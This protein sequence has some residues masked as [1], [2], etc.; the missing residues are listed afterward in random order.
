[1]IGSG[2]T[3]AVRKKF[4][5]LF[6]LMLAT[7][8]LS[9]SAALAEQ[10]ETTDDG[11]TWTLSDSGVLTVTGT[12]EVT[13]KPYQFDSDTVRSLVVG[14]GVTKVR[15]IFY[16]LS[17]LTNLSLPDTVTELGLGTFFWCRSLKS[18][19]LPDN[20]S[21]L[22]ED[23]FPQDTKLFSRPGTATARALGRIGRGFST[24]E[25]ALY[26]LKYDYQD[27]QEIGLA[28]M[29][30][31]QAVTSFTVP[32]EITVIGDEAFS[33]CASLSEIVLH[34]GIR[35]IGNRAFDGCS[36]LKTITVPAG[37]SVVSSGAFVGC[38]ALRYAAIGT[39]GA[40]ALGRADYSFRIPGETYTLQYF[41]IIG[42]GMGLAMES[43]AKNTTKLIVPEGVTTLAYRL[44]ADCV[45]P[46][47]YVE[48]PQSITA[49]NIGVFAGQTREFYIKCQKGSYA[50]RF[51][52]ENGLQF[53]NGSSR[54]IGYQITDL[55][56]K[57]NFVVSNYVTKGM[58]ER[59]KVRA[60]HDWLVHNAHYDLTYSNYSAN[61]VLLKGYGVCQSYAEA[62]EKLLT[63]AGLA[64]RLLS[65]KANN[66]TGNG[67]EGHAWNLV[68]VDGQWYHLDVT[69]DDP[70]F[71]VG[72][73]AQD[74]SPAISGM[75]GYSYFLLTDKQI[76]KDHQWASGISADKNQVGTFHD[77]GEKYLDFKGGRYRL[78][79]AKKTAEL[80]GVKSDKVKKLEIPDEIEEGDAV[81]KVTAISAE[82]CSGLKKLASLSVGGEVKTIGEGAFRDC[83]KLSA[84]SLGKKVKT[85]GQN[86]FD[87]CDALK[88]IRCSAGSKAAA[89]ALQHGYEINGSGD[90]SEEAVTTVVLDGLKYELN[91]KKKTAVFA[92]SESP[93]LA[94]LVIPAQVMTE[95]GTRYKV[96]EIKAKACKSMKNLESL[97]VG[98]NVKSIGQSAFENCG[99]LKSVTF[100]TKNLKDSTVGKNAFR[101]IS[102][103][104]TFKCPKKKL[105]DYQE[106][107]P[108]KGAPKKSKFK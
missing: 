86:V 32:P 34:A 84:V 66:G 50:E 69:W 89:W 43:C 37:V 98:Q 56:K 22:G 57:V 53:D 60:I 61:G 40:K 17:N 14:P 28:V 102:K 106:F 76:G 35:K 2:G 72:R 38:D 71:S 3:M 11:M 90:G 7:V 64:N 79:A 46:L 31:N 65:G 30:V 9:F 48:L 25:G 1:M 78:N 58:S 68:R 19:S 92:G 100:K 83:Q 47:E 85:I 94:V 87:G 75:E 95:D 5:L 81:Y 59:Q 15:I 36:A 44:F 108:K 93:D 97:T 13:D 10:T 99:N 41:N 63:R 29:N 42:G 33:G 49:L 12:G 88:S 67:F 26:D 73:V 70:V 74:S 51:A 52:R 45:K 55:T 54:V 96:T 20:I 8:V 82:C 18:V 103:K 105:K 16:H 91:A 80:I 6:L 104:A 21:V 101:K 62:T 4:L 77:N 39:D 23:V 24:A 27:G 107:L